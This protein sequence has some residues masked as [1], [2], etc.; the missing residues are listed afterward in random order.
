MRDRATAVGH[1]DADCFY[2]SAERVRDEF[3]RDKPVGV[4]GNQGACVI[5]KSYEMKAAGVKTG[6]PIW[7]ALPKCP[8]GV[9]VK[10]DFRWYEVL[11]RLMLEAVRE[12]SPRVEYYSIDE[13]FFLA[14]P[15][16]GRTFQEE[17]VAIRDRV[18]ERVGVPVTVGLARSRTLAKLISDATK[19]YGARAVLDPGAE[20][21]LLADRPVTEI[22][23]IAG[24]RAARLRAWG[25]RTC[26][27]LAR[28]DRRLVR[29]VL[30]ATGEAL[31]WELNGDPVQ[32][33]RPERP[34]HKAL[35]RGGSFGES[36][37]DP[38][39][40]YAW[41]V[42]NVERLIEELEYHAVLAGRLTV[43]VAY[44]DGQV[45][46]GQTTLAVP[47][48]RFDLLLDAARP[49]LRRA[50]VPRVLATRMHLI[51]ERLTP[52]RQAP[53][54]L[55]EPPAARAEAVARLKRAV[56]ARHGRFALRSA[57]TLPLVGVYRDPANEYDICDVRGKIYF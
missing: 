16:R 44:K 22:T 9:Y 18:R 10:R 14:A 35:S 3:L 4:L 36:T 40:L 43:W 56:N 27:D 7:E 23:G 24:R 2:V 11:S 37:A 53:L 1:L 54:G 50:W 21:A 47:T 30:T 55:F 19:P 57:A 45:G 42:R 28:A 15:G 31:W 39:I 48:D 34:L 51:A 49:C 52:R 13:F 8:G 32:P 12:L 46:V 41:L 29:E 5:A 6:E 33:I 20:E 17:A 25:V 26:L 38:V